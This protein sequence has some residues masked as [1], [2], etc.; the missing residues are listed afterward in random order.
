MHSIA[1]I[2]MALNPITPTIIWSRR[3]Q[4]NRMESP[5]PP[6]TRGM[7]ALIAIISTMILY[8][9]EGVANGSKILAKAHG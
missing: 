2:T 6:K 4:K 8:R 3:M 1:T 7:Q 9:P 5:M